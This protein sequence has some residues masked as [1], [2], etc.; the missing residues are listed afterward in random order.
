[1]ASLERNRWIWKQLMQLPNR[2]RAR[3]DRRRARPDRCHHRGM[4]ALGA[5]AGRCHRKSEIF[6]M[7]REPRSLE[8]RGISALGQPRRPALARI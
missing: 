7:T 8:P 2:S 3:P 6:E 4:E 1:V 5:L